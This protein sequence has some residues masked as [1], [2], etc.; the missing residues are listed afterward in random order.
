MMF[1]RNWCGLKPD[2]GNFV[3][4]IPRQIVSIAFI[5]MLL[6]GSRLQAES[7]TKEELGRILFF[8]PRLSTTGKI[9]CNSCHQVDAPKTGLPSGTDGTKVSVGVFSFTGT[10]NAPTVWNVGLRSALFWDGR[11][12]TLEEQALGP[13]TNPIEMG[14]QTPETIAKRINSIDAYKPLFRKAFQKEKKE[15]IKIDEVVEA[16]ALYQRS[17]LTPNS[18]FDLYQK[19]DLSALSEKQI[20]GWKKFQSFSCIACHGAAL[21]QPKDHFV[22][23][24]MHPVSEYEEKY[25]FSLDFGRSLFTKEP[26]DRHKWRVPSLRNVALTAPYF[27]NGSVD[28][29]SEAIRIMGK[30]QLGRDLSESDVSELEAFLQSLTGQIPIQKKPKL[31]GYSQ[32]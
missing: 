27:H 4:I 2:L 26:R 1:I 11:A 3:S 9:S 21:F 23:F 31:P 18:A 17:L 14:E 12:R 19:G 8:D 6:L 5:F 13:L 28:K 24:P 29:L 10:R 7:F 22:R 15:E 30:A 16:I 32:K 25:Q 20:R